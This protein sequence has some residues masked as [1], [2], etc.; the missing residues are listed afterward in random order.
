M[1][2]KY[3]FYWFVA[4][5]SIYNTFQYIIAFGNVE[6]KALIIPIFGN[7]ILLISFFIHWLLMRMFGQKIIGIIDSIFVIFN[8]FLLLLSILFDIS[9]NLFEIWFYIP[10]YI[11][12]C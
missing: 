9:W 7:A 11:F 3:F 1:L 5:C 2:K 6:I 4:I 12:F 10:A 8:S